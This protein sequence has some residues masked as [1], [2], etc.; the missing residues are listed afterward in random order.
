MLAALACS[1]DLDC[2]LNGVCSSGGT[3]S[4]DKPWAGAACEQ[5]TFKPASVQ[6]AY[7]TNPSV[8]TWGGGV[9]FDGKKHHLFASRMT[10]GCPLADW[11]Q[12][13]RIDHAVSSNGVEG[14]Y[15]FQDV[16]IPTWSHNAAPIT[17]HDGSYAIIHIGTGVGPADGGKN[18]SS[19]V[20]E[21]GPT[22]A[23]HY[24]PPSAKWLEAAGGST[25]HVSKSL[26]GPWE[27]LPTTLGGCNNPAPWVHPNG[28]IFVGCGGA[29]KRAESLAGPFT[30]V[31]SFPMSGGPEGH[32]E[33]PQV[34]F[35]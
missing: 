16:A 9:I 20:E 21:E 34:M 25:I 8:T 7:G 3:C 5:M 30:T 4:C 35:P 13:S 18:C 17:L 23:K 15:E 33:D 22:A 24:T 12:N 10:N 1:S 19:L 32:Y 26:D 6:P 27:P 29:F 31:A 11:T 2:S 14:P 28:T